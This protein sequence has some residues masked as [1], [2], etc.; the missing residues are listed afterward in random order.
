MR[1]L[2][3]KNERIPRIVVVTS[4]KLPGIA[5]YNHIQDVMYINNKL[6]NAT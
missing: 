4:K 1:I 5:A 2:D 6:G 3:G